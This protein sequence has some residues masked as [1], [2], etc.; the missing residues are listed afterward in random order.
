MLSI[1][2]AEEYEFIKLV[3]D[4]G[5]RWLGGTDA[6]TEGVWKWDSGAYVT[7]TQWDSYQPDNNND[8]DCMVVNVAWNTWV[9]DDQRCVNGY[10]S[11]CEMEL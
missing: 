2:T 5:L 7:F 4:A 9:W 1:E 8:A 11:V 3:F 10:K 6:A